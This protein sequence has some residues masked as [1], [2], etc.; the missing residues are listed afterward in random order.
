M[1][2]AERKPM[3]EI[4]SFVNDREKILII[5]CRGCVTVC[6]AGG[7]KEVEILASLLRLEAQNEGRN[8]TVDE[9]ILERQCDPEYIEEVSPL[10]D[11]RYDAI[12]SMACSIGPQ[13]LSE[14]YPLEKVFPALNTCFLGGALSHGLWVERCQACGNCLIHFFGGLCPIARCAKSLLH[15]PCGGSANGKCE[16]SKETDCVWH[17]IVERLIAQGLMEEYLKMDLLKNWKTSRDG[18]QRRI[19]REELLK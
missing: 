5:G 17:F 3:D 1:I 15:G 4:K 14:R 8:L 16:V 10:L 7:A 13:F 19:L 2:I 9:F 18:G 12:L 11:R 6:N